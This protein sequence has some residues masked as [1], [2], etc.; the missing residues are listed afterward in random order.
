MYPKAAPGRGPEGSGQWC[1]DAPQETIG[2][3][4]GEEEV[5][6]GQ[7]QEPVDG[8]AQQAAQDVFAETGEE[9]SHILHLHNLASH[10]EQD[11]HRGIPNY[12]GDRWQL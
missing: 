7:D 3:L 10:Q 8:M 6:E 4:P 12:T 2:V 11:A 5:D 9:H 1:H